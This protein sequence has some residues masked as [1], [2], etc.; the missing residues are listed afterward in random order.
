[1]NYRKVSVLVPTRKR[2][3]YLKRMLDSYCASITDPTMSEF[4]FRCD[5]D[6]IESVRQLMNLQW[7]IIVGPRR[8]GYKSL[9]TFYNEMVRIA[10][11][12]LLICGN[13]DMLF[14]TKDWPRLIIEEAAKYPDGIF[15]IGVSTGLNDD[16]FPFSI[17]SR[18]FVDKLGKIN[19]ERLL[20]SDIFL[21][22]VAKHFNRAVVLRS[23]MFH[24]DWAG[25]GAD[26][27]R[28]EANKHEFHMVFANAQ[29]DWTDDYRQLHNKVVAEAVAK[30]DS[31]GDRLVA[32]VIADFEQYTPPK[33]SDG[34][35]W[36]PQAR[37]LKWGH[38]GGNS[39]V[40]YGRRETATLMKRI[41]AAGI[42]RDQVVLSSLQNGLPSILWSHL[43][44]KVTTIASRP[45]GGET[46]KDGQHTI[47]FG[48]LG[49]TRFLYKV[50]ENVGTLNLLVLDELSYASMIS[51]YYLFRHA[52]TRPGM[53][54]FLNTKERSDNAH[55]HVCRFLGDLCSGYID[56]ICHDIRDIVED[57]G[58]GISYEIV[59]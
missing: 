54:V 47:A 12:D 39:S 38:P 2:P 40:H 30:L 3:A 57:D 24:H 5:N 9:P 13:D 43:F 25:H 6:D 31:D 48:S 45:N 59:E 22:D 36:P 14:E 33:S 27:T 20:F 21:L 50:I 23:V 26:E 16:K 19:D 32:G 42:S 49:D 55:A 53:V 7:P 34:K 44:K 18:Q 4:V 28:L 1:M 11:G 17:V 41:L 15:N 52:L 51:P 58:I 29:G 10:T 35:S 46:I 56:G 37:P 8:E